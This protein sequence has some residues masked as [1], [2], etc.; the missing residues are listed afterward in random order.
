MRELHRDTSGRYPARVLVVEDEPITRAQITQILSRHAAEVRAVANGAEGLDMWR[1]WQPD[2]VVTDILMPV[3]DGLDMSQAIKREAP[4]AQIVV[5]SA[6][7]EQHHLRRAIDIGVE[8]Y[9]AKPVDETMLVDALVKCLRDAHYQ[10]ELRMSRLVFESV[11]EGVMVTDADARIL[12]VNP[13]FSELTGYREDEV[14][15]QTAHML[16]SGQHDAA[17]YQTMRESL[18]SLGRWSGEI[19][20]RRKNGELYTEWLSLVAVEEPGRQVT[21]YVGVFS[22]IT[23][24]KREEEHIR[25]LAHYDVLTGL[26]NRALFLDRMRRAL[27]RAERRGGHLAVLYLDLDQFKPVND[28]HGHAFGDR[29]LAEVAHRL[30]ASVRDVDMVS[31]RGGDEFVILIEAADAQSAAGTVAAKLIQSVSA[32]YLIDGVEARIGACVGI[33]LYPEHGKAPERLLEAADAA[34]YEAKRRGRGGFL[35]AGNTEDP[36]PNSPSRIEAALVEGLEHNRFELRY[37]PEISLSGQ[38]VERIEALLR[39]RHPQLGLLEAEHFVDVAERMGLLPALGQQTLR[40]ALGMLN[41]HGHPD[42]GLSLDMSARQLAMLGDISPLLDWLAEAGTAT[43]RITFEFPEHAVTGNEEG[44]R[45]LYI[46]TQHGF[47]CGLDDFGAGYCSFG[48]LQQL[49]L[50]SIKIDLSFIEEI[51]R[52]AQSRELV[53][54]LIAFGKR[55]GL[56]TVAEGVDSRAQLDFL[57]ANGCD[58]AQGYLFGQPLTADDLP[59]YL[60]E[61]SWRQFF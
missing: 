60:R 44:L 41:L 13:A 31:R 48:L 12:A 15:G 47:K 24:R 58:A 52:S 1:A 3:M 32:P 25:R 28:T 56:R 38:R 23:E 43:Q 26:P 50:S 7:S 17:F 49:P 27:A 34:L 46:L 30:S 16:S 5:V 4:E 40:Q 45:M 61:A 18:D 37:L 14:L 59:C 22:D 9:V 33:A 35:F 2:V 10:A 29:V 20:N 51:E 39:F 8:R 55:L 53:A 42:I 6:S 19:N 57:R 54:A 36:L 11:S 21:R